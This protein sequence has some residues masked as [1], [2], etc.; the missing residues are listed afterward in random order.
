MSIG[1]AIMGL[2]FGNPMQQAVQPP[3]PQG[4]PPAAGGPGAG[5]GGPGAAGG[6]PGAPQAQPQPQ[7]Y[8]SPPDLS[9]MYVKLV[10]QSR[11][12]DSFD[13]GLALMAGGFKGPPG[14]AQTIMN[15]VGPPLDAGATMNN[16]MQLQQFHQQQL[17]ALD[18]AG[19][20]GITPNEALAMPTDT[21]RTA[22]A[23]GIQP[24]Q[25]RSYNAWRQQYITQ[26]AK[27]PDPATGQPIG[28]DGAGKAFDQQVPMSSM[29]LPGG[30]DQAMQR[31]RLRSADWQ[32]SH[33]G[34]PVPDYFN[35]DE[36]LAAH[37]ADFA[38]KSGAQTAAAGTFPALDNNLTT[39]RSKVEQIQKAPNLP[40]LL[41]R[42]PST[43]Q[44]A[45]NS[46]GWGPLIA[47]GATDLN[48]DDLKTLQDIDE[49]SNTNTSALVAANPHLAANIQTIQQNL[50]KLGNFTVGSDNYGKTLTDLTDSIDTARGQAA[51]A[52][53]QLETVIKT[54]AEAKIPDSYLPGG[55]NYIRDSKRLPPEEIANARAAIAQGKPPAA[56]IR[57]L[58]LRGYLPRPGEIPGG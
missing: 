28:P 37:D 6:A 7:A 55:S 8:Q 38:A 2:M 18:A 24:E 15:S 45:R 41:E 44:L 49:L 29:M 56:V 12:A 23:I 27:D 3:G 33:P 58:K 34:E 50:G 14:G 17:G 5:G 25:L 36:G 13:R 42:A 21:V 9:Q 35:S 11:A 1:D 22:M 16:I 39:L 43:I 31:R 54:P 4:G 46:G 26:H 47:K 10:Q 19:K 53:G 48:A 57:R 20:L 40:T 32:T 51:G 52:S 30:G